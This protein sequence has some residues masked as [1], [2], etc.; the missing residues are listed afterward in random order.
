MRVA[1]TIAGS[2]PSGGAGIQA[3]LKTFQAHG[4]FGMS[5][6]TAVTVQNT[7]KVYDVQEIE[8]VIVHEQILRVFEDIAVDAVK[9]GMVSSIA[10]IDSIADALGRVSLPPVV[11]D[12]VMI[13]KSGYSLLRAEARTALVERLFPLAEI[14]TPNIHEAELLAGFTIRTLPEMEAAARQMVA[15]GA[16]KAVI[17]GGHLAGE[18]AVDLA[19]DGVRCETMTA[20][21]I[22]TRNTHGTGCTFS[23]AV[24]ANLARG[25]AFFPAV[26]AAKQYITEA[27]RRAP[28]LGHGAGPLNHLVPVPSISPP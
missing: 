1:L 6:V 13:S 24:A 19:Y 10:L 5:A 28:D 9:I 26:A 25:A 2:D 20:P 12:P 17:K 15:A 11:L 22:A 14:V 7:R 21:R 3:D 4:L 18:A 23:S 8:P 16:A 27:I